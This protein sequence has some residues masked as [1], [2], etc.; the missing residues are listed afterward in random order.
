MIHAQTLTQAHMH[1]HTSLCVPMS[2]VSKYP[3][4]AC[5]MMGTGG[6]E[7]PCAWGADVLP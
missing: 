1:T 4:R 5:Y 7:D 3:L 6:K 2:V